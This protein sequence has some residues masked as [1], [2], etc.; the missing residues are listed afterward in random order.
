MLFPIP[1]P[2]ANGQLGVS[3]AVLFTASSSPVKVDSITVVNTDSLTRTFNLFVTRVGSTA[4]R[5]TPVNLSL[6]AGA[7][8]EG[9]PVH[10]GNGDS[11]SGNASTAAVLDYNI[12]ATAYV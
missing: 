5:I 12:T 7:M 2:V 9:S 6:I 4:R 1:I 10:L 3:T 11:I 8:Y